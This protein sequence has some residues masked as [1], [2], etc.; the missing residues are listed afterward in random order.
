MLNATNPIMLAA[1]R[2]L[3]PILTRKENVPYTLSFLLLCFMAGWNMWQVKIHVSERRDWTTE[4]M[5]TDSTNRA[6]RDI[7][8]RELGSIG[9]DIANCREMYERMSAEFENY[10]KKNKKR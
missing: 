7:M 10:K 6:E 8:I 5:R 9:R 4:R 1:L 3:I 2:F